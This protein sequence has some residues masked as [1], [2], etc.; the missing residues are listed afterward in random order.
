MELKNIQRLVDLD[1]LGEV[2]EG[3]TNTSSDE[4]DYSSSPEGNKSSGRSDSDQTSDSTFACT[5]NREF[6]SLAEVVGQHPAQD[7]SRC[8]EIGIEHCVHSTDGSVEGGS[9][10]EA[11]PA[12]PDEAC[13]NE[14]HCDV[15][16]AVSHTGLLILAL[17]QNN[18]I[19]KGRETG[20][21]VNGPT[22]IP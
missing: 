1:P 9:S 14:D 6:P 15:V 16:R 7:S 17:A 11:E 12:K 21:N 13:S 10:V 2:L 19:G 8:S 3:G 20:C 18:C 4:A 5:N 22:L